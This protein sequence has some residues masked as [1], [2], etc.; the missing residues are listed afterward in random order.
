MFSGWWRGGAST[1][2]ALLGILGYIVNALSVLAER[3]LLI[4]HGQANRTP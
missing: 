1:R 3:R 4:R 2:P